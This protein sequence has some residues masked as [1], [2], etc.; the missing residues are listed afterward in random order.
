MS[1]RV[2]DTIAAT[3]AD[4]PVFD[5]HEHAW[6]AFSADHSQEFDL[7]YLLF[8][9]VDLEAAGFR[10]EPS[11]FDYLRAPHLPDGAQKAWRAIRPFLES[12][13]TTSYFRCLSRTLDGLFGVTEEEVF[14]DGWQDASERVRRYSQE[15]KAKGALLCSRMRVTATVLDAKLDPGQSLSTDAVDHRVLHVVRLDMFIHEERELAKTPLQHPGRDFEEWLEAFDGAFHRSLEAGAAGFKSA[16]AYNRRIEYS[17]P[18]KDEVARV[19]KRGLLSAPPADKTTYQDFM[20]NR[21][22]RLCTEAGVP[23]QIHTGIQAGTGH[24]LEDSRP[25]LL[26]GLFR[27]H[28]DLRI[29]L[30]HG[31]YPWIIQAGLMAKY[32]PNVYIDGCWL[33]RVSPSAYRAALTS[34]I[35]TVPLNKIFAWGGDSGIL[36]VSYGSLALAK[37]LIADVLADLVERGYFDPDLARHVA[38]RILHD[39][40]MD[41]WRTGDGAGADP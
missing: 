23:L 13:R 5:H 19:F 40:G 17:D 18:S 20:M 27:R 22:C 12:V 10:P 35:E 28:G 15:N 30:F 37:D 32:F 7:P 25:T 6:G 26:T 29:E 24:V 34:W 2:R 14:S 4:M 21:L 9:A 38:R 36:E 41:F 16:L 39:N 1:S 33:P 8:S 11:L 31:G 3:I